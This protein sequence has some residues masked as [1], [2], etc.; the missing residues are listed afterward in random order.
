MNLLI[1]TNS[2]SNNA[3]YVLNVYIPTDESLVDVAEYS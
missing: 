1:G 2:I 3:V